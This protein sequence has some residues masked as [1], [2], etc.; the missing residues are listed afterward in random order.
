MNKTLPSNIII[1][2]IVI[3]ALF[4]HLTVSSW[5][6][7]IGCFSLAI[8]ACDNGGN[9]V[10]Q[11]EVVTEATADSLALKIAV[12]PTLDCLPLYVADSEGIF[13]RESLDVVLCP[14][15][16]Q[17]DCDTAITGGSVQ[18][19]ATDLVRAERLQH[20]GT[21]LRYA[22][23]TNLQ[24]QLLTNKTARIRQLKQLD[25]KM[26][27]V[28]RYS[29]TAMITDMLVDRA[30]LLT[31]R[32]FRI[33]VNDVTVRLSMLETGVMDA[34]LLPEP[35]ATVARNLKANMVYDSESDSLCLGV[36]AFNEKA[37][38]Q[39]TLR[40][41]QMEAF[42]RAY[43]AACDSINGKGIGQY[44][45]LIAQWCH[46]K[47]N[48]ADSLAQQHPMA[49]PHSTPPR[50]SDIDRAKKWLGYMEPKSSTDTKKPKRKKK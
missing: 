39:D 5:L 32:V 1:F 13:Q 42:I 15:M 7:A 31:E 12:M 16:A 47:A 25:D 10:T 23:A 20:Q 30:G 19:M 24:W 22:T 33:Q 17:M 48:V 27:A 18:A 11:G 8:G 2:C 36:I 38:Q 28:T 26:V 43:N 35:Q 44:R 9:T 45:D 6:F 14:F 49:F 34:L 3:K 50:Q 37:L 40:R 4:T 21:P 29:A 46:V 41:W